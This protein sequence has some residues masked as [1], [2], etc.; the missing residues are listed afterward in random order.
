MRK[1]DFMQKEQHMQS[2]PDK[3]QHNIFRQLSPIQVVLWKCL[4]GQPGWGW[5]D[6]DDSS[7]L[8]KGSLGL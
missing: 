3:K 5:S 8:S 1:G 6:E 4:E 7:I 2:H